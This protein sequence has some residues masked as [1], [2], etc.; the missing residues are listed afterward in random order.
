M[1]DSSDEGFFLY[2]EIGSCDLAKAG[3]HLLGSSNLS[4]VAGTT[5]MYHQALLLDEKLKRNFKIRKHI[6]I[7]IFFCV[8]G[9]AHMLGK[10]STTEYISSFY[11]QHVC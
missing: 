9:Q 2:F 3:L 5:G 11:F 6:C 1:T 7:L 8:E 10:C 4:P